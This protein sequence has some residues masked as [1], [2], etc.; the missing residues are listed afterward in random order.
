MDS[1]LEK[2]LKE[3]KESEELQQIAKDNMTA[4]EISSGRKK[5]YIKGIG[6]VIM[7]WPSPDLTMQGDRLYAKFVTE[8]LQEGDLLTEEQLKAIYGKPTYIKV[9]GK[10]VKVG[11]GQWTIEEENKMEELPKEIRIM[12]AEFLDCREV[13]QQMLTA[14]KGGQV[15]NEDKKQ[16]LLSRLDESFKKMG[17]AK[18]KL[19][20]LQSKRLKLFSIS[21]EEQANL[22]KIKL[23]A[24]QCIKVEKEG[25]VE[26]LW[27]SEEEYNSGQFDSLRILSIFNL[28][29][30]GAD[31]RFFGDIPEEGISS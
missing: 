26:P 2:K 11:Q 4:E 8:H 27:K 17:E 25:K 18:L 24:P 20:E 29:L 13:Y 1:E 10:E 14:E 3:T 23:Y 16:N 9:R 22:E 5:V 30:R 7:D 12:E 31:V 15:V 19:L 21:L 6:N 28:F